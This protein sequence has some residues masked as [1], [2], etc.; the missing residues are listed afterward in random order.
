MGE[1]RLVGVAVHEGVG[2]ITV[3]NPPVNALG[4]GV[5]EGIA[6]AVERLEADQGVTAM[7]LMGEGR[8]FI[9]GADIR[10][11]GKPRPPPK[12]R[13]DEVLEASHKPIVAAI[14]GYALG[15]GL[16][17]ALACHYRIAQSTAKLG[18]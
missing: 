10:Q 8:G 16:E 2:V 9:A 14:H 11:F 17:L 3:D 15:G 6:A 4:P 7:V 13:T 1:E 5:R 18:L 12:R